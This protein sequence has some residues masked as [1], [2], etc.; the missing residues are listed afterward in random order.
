MGMT[1]PDLLRSYSER[2][3]K[4]L[5]AFVPEDLW[6]LLVAGKES[7][8]AA[9]DRVRAAFGEVEQRF[10]YD[11]GAFMAWAEDALTATQLVTG[12]YADLSR[13]LLPST[14]HF[15]LPNS[16][17][18][19]VP[20]DKPDAVR[21]QG[22]VLGPSEQRWQRYAN[23]KAAA[24]FI[25][26]RLEGPNLP[27]WEG[28]IS[29]PL[30]LLEVRGLEPA[31]EAALIARHLTDP[32]A[33][34]RTAYRLLRYEEGTPNIPNSLVEAVAHQMNRPKMTVRKWL[35]RGGFRL[36]DD[37]A[38]VLKQAQPKKRAKNR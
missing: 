38:W 31:D 8:P 4:Q 25:S 32:G 10:R 12:T 30:I 2:F 15:R 28:P 34:G 7:V 29:D 24:H 37:L 1:K 22:N 5:R 6:V 36:P 21:K 16:T 13:D 18:V 11:P 35:I 23:A 27:S 3:Q 19:A 33:E 20:S 17:S 26:T 14:L 9:L